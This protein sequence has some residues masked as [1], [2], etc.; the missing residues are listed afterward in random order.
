MEERRAQVPVR[1]APGGPPGRGDPTAVGETPTARLRT[2]VA[3]RETTPEARAPTAREELHGTRQGEVRDARRARQPPRARERGTPPRVTAAEASTA[4]F[5]GAAEK[6]VFLKAL[7]SVDRRDLAGRAR[8]ARALGAV[9]HELSAKALSALLARDPS[10]EVRRECVSSLTALGRGEGLPAVEGALSDTSAVVRLAAVRGVYSL[11]GPA[12]AA[13]LVRMLSD[14]H[15]D[16]PAEGGR[17]P[18]L[19]GG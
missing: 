11:A 18:G 19:A 9:Q 17:L 2:P 7:A 14:E 5:A 12:S 3:P 15:E 6:L 16:V 10:P 13:S 1:R 4:V 8:A